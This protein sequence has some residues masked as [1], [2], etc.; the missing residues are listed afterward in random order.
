MKNEAEKLYANERN[1]IINKLGIDDTFF[2]ENY[3]I[4]I[5]NHYFDGDDKANF[6]Y[7]T[8]NKMS[9]KINL[10][11]LDSRYYEMMS[12]MISGVRIYFIKIS[13]EYQGEVAWK[14]KYVPF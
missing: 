6:Y 8:Y 4:I 14:T 13:K 2:E 12:E 3:I 5:A 9:K 7:I 1:Q 11:K 10:V